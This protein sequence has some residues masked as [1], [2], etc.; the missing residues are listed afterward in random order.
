[1]A[2]YTNSTL[3]CHTLEYQNKLNDFIMESED[4]TEALHDRIWTVVLKVMEDADVPCE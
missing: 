2:M 1:M 3:F 4:A